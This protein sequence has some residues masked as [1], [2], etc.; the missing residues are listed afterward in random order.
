[1]CDPRAKAMGGSIAGQGR[2]YVSMVRTKLP[3]ACDAARVCMA[4]REGTQE[5][6]DRA[7]DGGTEH[8]RVG[9]MVMAGSCE[10]LSTS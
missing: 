1:M 7:G 5:R 8:V 2:R 4:I 3:E 10:P 6:K 9:D